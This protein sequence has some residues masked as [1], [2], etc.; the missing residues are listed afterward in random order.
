[1]PQQPLPHIGG[2]QPG[3]AQRQALAVGLLQR[4]GEL[5]GH[6]QQPRLPLSQRARLALQP[7]IVVLGADQRGQCQPRALHQL[8]SARKTGLSGTQP[9]LGA[10]GNGIGKL[11]IQ[12]RKLGVQVADLLRVGQTQRLGASHL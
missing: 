11:A 7:R 1:M 3:A 8:Q 6:G 12:A 5:T 10:A 9:H 2:G 4:P